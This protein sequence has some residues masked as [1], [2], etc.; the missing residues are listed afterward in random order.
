MGFYVRQLQE[1]T[2][3]AKSFTKDSGKEYKAYHFP[4]NPVFKYFVAT[5]QEYNH[6]LKLI[7]RRKERYRKKKGM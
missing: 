4:K 3:Y 1:A 7:E 5:E 6:E 2:D